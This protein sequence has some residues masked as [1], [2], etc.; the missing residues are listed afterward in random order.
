MYRHEI[1]EVVKRNEET[2]TGL[3]NTLA[4]FE[5]WLHDASTEGKRGVPGAK[6]IR[7]LSDAGITGR[8]LLITCGAVYLYQDRNLHTMPNQDSLRFQLAHQIMKVLPQE[9][10]VSSTGKRHSKKL[11]KPERKEIGEYIDKSLGLLFTNMVS[12]ANKWEERKK[13]FVN[14]QGERME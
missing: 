3:K 5:R 14:E 4:W 7:R 9:T 11:T 6:H 2:H 1:N 12:A 13:S 10:K 8:E